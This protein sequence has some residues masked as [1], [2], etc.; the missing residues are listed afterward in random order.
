MITRDSLT[1]GLRIG[2]LFLTL[3]AFP[4]SSQAAELIWE[5]ENRFRLFLDGQAFTEHLK[6]WQSLSPEEKKQ[7]ILSAERRLARAN[8]F[9]WAESVYAKTCWHPREHSYKGCRGKRPDYLHPR[10]HK[11]RVQLKGIG[12]EGGRCAWHILPLS[13]DRNVRRKFYARKHAPCDRAIR[14]AIPYPHGAE[15]AVFRNGRQLLR[16]KIRVKDIF[17][18]GLGDSFAAGD[19]NP[20]RPVRFSRSR[21]MDYGLDPKGRAL[22]GYPARAGRWERMGDPAFFAQAAKWQSRP[23]HRSLYSHQLRAALQLSLE[24]PHR[25]VTFA[26]FS[27]AGSEVISGLFLLYKGTDWDVGYPQLSQISAAAEAQCGPHSA[28]TVRYAT[29]YADGGRV[30]QLRD[31]DL[32]KC[33]KNQR[34]ID[35]L[36]LSIGGNDVGFSRLVANAV[37]SDKSVLKK[38]GGWTGGVHGVTQAQKEL[39]ALP[40][41]Y[42]LLNR[43]FHFVL[44]IPWRQPDRILLTAYPKISFRED[45]KTPCGANSR[46]MDVFEDFRVETPK[47]IA[48]ERFARQLY[49]TM[50]RAARRHGWTFVDRHR[51]AFS[52][53]GFCA[54]DAKSRSRETDAMVFPRKQDESWS[55]FVPAD[56]RPYGPRQR[57]V[58][59]PNDAFLTV[60]YHAAG[61]VVKRVL[62]NKRLAWFQVVLAAT[63]GGAF[64]PTAEGQAVIAD[65]LA[66]KARK[67]LAKYGQ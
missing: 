10:S 56:Y 31:L 44:G 54:E 36:F 52:A 11:V 63:Y 47:L 26:G 35:L 14:L 1:S 46:G 25:A 5:V 18:V 64:H 50:K 19:G 53:H 24:D 33:Y 45:G 2:G 6:V 38:V 8:P 7:P 29:A 17:I 51:D 42:K 37:F 59:T 34:P 55:P 57:W 49:K 58:R 21:A 67:V 32:R 16:K 9:G 48:G 61:A 39:A 30:P 13:P 22:S 60:N 23:C 40:R 3:I 27:C 28:K 4:S 65:A 66:D 20:D 43:A 12:P 62:R 15:I 41:L